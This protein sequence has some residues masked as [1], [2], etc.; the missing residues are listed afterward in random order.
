M[1]Q[2][3]TARLFT[4]AYQ[5]RFTEWQQAAEGGW[6]DEHEVAAIMAG[7][8]AE[9]AA[10]TARVG[11][12]ELRE[13]DAASARLYM[14][15]LLACAA[16]TANVKADTRRRLQ[17]LLVDWFPVEY[18]EIPGHRFRYDWFSPHEAT[19][20]EHFGHLADR[21]GVRA[22]EI[23]SFEGRSAC[24]ILRNLVCGA[25]GQLI[26][27]DPF[28]EDP[29]QEANFDHNIRSTGYAA[30]TV[31]LRGTS[32]QVLPFLDATSFD[33]VYVDGSHAALDVI[34]DAARCWSLLKTG[35]FLVF[36]DYLSVTYSER[37]G[38]C[39]TRGIDA[40]LELTAGEYET[41]FRGVQLALRKTAATTRSG[42]SW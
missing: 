19:W 31:K 36:D 35:G 18:L 16:D 12:D 13:A 42:H 30:R 9:L 2:V 1:T 7:T 14:H 17:H 22:L 40:F 6:L 8:E 27:V 15:D 3:R 34:A 11:K 33:F 28:T 29:R 24:W 5:D 4:A 32:H 41:L 23:G 25:D 37:S 21:T 10:L 38:S 39:A 20:R 26:C